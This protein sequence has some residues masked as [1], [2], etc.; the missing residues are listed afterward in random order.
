M[1]VNPDPL[2]GIF[3]AALRVHS[4]RLDTLAANLA[5]ADTP[6]FQARDVDFRAVL[7]SAQAG[8]LTPQLTHARH[9]GAGSDGAAPLLWRVPLQPSADGNTVDAQIEQASFAEAALRYEATLRF[10]DGRVKSLLSAISG[11]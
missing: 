9:L 10:M 1:A 7:S 3:P 5:N 11:D 6:G 8:A 4:Q 2:F